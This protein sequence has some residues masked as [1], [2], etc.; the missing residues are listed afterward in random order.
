MQA[1]I[2]KIEDKT[3]RID[4]DYVYYYLLEGN[5]RALLIDSGVYDEDVREIASSITNLP[6]T[7]VNTHGDR[8]HTAGNKYFDEFYIS[9]LDYEKCNIKESCPNAAWH[10]LK[11]GQ[12][13][14]LGERVLKVYEIP[15]HTYGSVAFLDVNNRFLF[16][17]DTVSD[18]I[19]FLFGNHRCPDKYIESLKKLVH[20]ESEY[21]VIFPAHGTKRLKSG[22]ARKVLSDWERVL[23][24]E[25]TSTKS[26]VHGRLVD[27]YVLENCG[28]YY[29]I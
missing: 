4:N 1:K 9:R 27:T 8:D 14:D 11:E 10:E 21:N 22:Y 7:L 17:G 18:A 5:E 26:D 25:A 13:F 15:G 19:I 6:I 28:F 16:S 24:G 12:V 23:K 3:Y 2:E 29:E 20:L